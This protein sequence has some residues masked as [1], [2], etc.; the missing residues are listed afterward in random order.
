MAI[1][2]K[3]PRGGLVT[4]RLP[5]PTINSVGRNAANKRAPY[6]AE[7]LDNCF[8][9]LE[10]NIEKRPGFEV[11]PQYTIPDKT[12]W[13]FTDYS[14]R[15]DLYRLAGVGLPDE[16]PETIENK[17]FWY[18]WHNINEDNRYLVVIDFKARTNDRAL[19]YVFQIL[20]N[21]TWQDVTPCGQPGPASTVP[22]ETRAY[23]TFGSDASDLGTAKTAAESLQAVSVGTNIVIL[24]KNVYAGFTSDDDGFLFNLKGEKTT[25]EDIAGK[26]VTYYTASEVIKVINAGSDNRV[27]TADDIVLGYRPLSAVRNDIVKEIT[28]HTSNPLVV[29]VVL[30]DLAVSQGGAYVGY[31]LKLTDGPASGSNGTI[32]E[33]FGATKTARVSWSGAVPQVSGTI[34]AAPYQADAVDSEPIPAVYTSYSI[35]L[36]PNASD[37]GGT[38]VNKNFEVNTGPAT[39]E[40]RGKVTSYDAP[41]RTAKVIDWSGAAP[42]VGQSF[43]LEIS[44]PFLSMPAKYYNGVITSTPVPLNQKTLT[45]YTLLPLTYG[46]P[47][48]TT[49]AQSINASIATDPNNVKRVVFTSNDHLLIE[50]QHVFVDFVTGYTNATVNTASGNV[51]RLEFTSTNHGLK[52]DDKLYIDFVSGTSLADAIYTV[53][54]APTANTFTVL[55]NSN[56]TAITNG[57]AVIRKNSTDGSYTVETVPDKDTFTII[58]GTNTTAISSGSAVVKKAIADYYKD[59]KLQ[60]LYVTNPG[61]GRVIK[62]DPALN[63]AFVTN[64]LG[65]APLNGNTYNLAITD[66]TYEIGDKIYNGVD[67]VSITTPG[68]AGVTGDYENVQLEY[69]SG[70]VAT[71]YPKANITIANGEV[72]T[73]T[74]VSNYRGSGFNYTSNPT[75]MKVTTGNG[76]PATFRCTVASLFVQEEAKHIP[77]EDYSYFQKSLS[78]LGQKVNDASEIRLPPVIDDWYELNRNTKAPIDITASEMLKQ[79]Y[80][81]S[82]PYGKYT[83]EDGRFTNANLV[84][85]RGKVYFCSNP[86][87]SLTSG[88]YRVVSWAEN[89]GTQWVQVPT[90]TNTP[91]IQ[92]T[93]PIDTTNWVEIKP[94]GRPYLQKVRTPE[95]WSVIDPRRMPQKLSL[96]IS[97]GP[98]DWTIGP[99][100]WTPRQSGNN[101][102]NPGPSVFRTTN[103]AELKQTQIISIAV[104]KDRLWFAA[105]DVAFSSQ[106]G[107]YES[108]FIDDPSNIVAT[109]PIDI[110]ASSNAFAQITHMVPFEDYIFINTKANTQFQLT[111]GSRD[112]NDIV[113][114]PF[115]VML[116]PATYYSAASFVDPQTIGSQLYFFD[117]RKLYLFTGKTNLGMNSAVEVSAT[118]N[119]YLPE[120]YGFACVGHAQNSVFVTDSDNP[121]HIYIYTIRFSG[122][123]V[124]QNSF[125]RYVLDEESA[126]YS[127]QVY[128]K[129]LYAIIHKNDRVL[130]ERTL[131][132]DE[133]PIIPRMDHMFKVRISTLGEN[134]NTTY[135]P[136]LHETTYRL[137]TA[138]YSLNDTFRVVI[139]PP[140]IQNQE[141]ISG[142]AFPPLVSIEEDGA[143]MNVVVLGR[144]DTEGAYV[145]IG[146]PFRMEVELSPLFVRDENGNIVDGT[147]NLRTVVVRHFNTG[148]YDIVV[149]HRGRTPIVSSFTAI[150]PDFTIQEDALPLE[151]WAQNGEFVG[152][153]FGFSESTKIKLVSEYIT[154]V[155]IS[156]IEF[157]GKF[158]QKYSAI[159]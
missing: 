102:N 155:N 85:G 138:N 49:A 62:Y 111:A 10:R 81:P 144:F 124:I 114:T 123:R 36:G 31:S 148:N 108:F 131:L 128:D 141:D 137:P 40:T 29:D 25:E 21:G 64:W 139:A 120:N 54:T 116:S 12:D 53:D 41:T 107:D 19:F 101:D 149:S 140:A 69:H 27:F 143:Y 48:A 119:D 84:Q 18:Y 146:N 122:D 86:F 115:N 117:R 99:I 45:P 127:M 71:E 152:K 74:I 95:K 59:Y 20:P 73:C 37:V 39:F 93:K 76:I 113:L 15:V 60:T 72:T 61:S 80:D 16:V 125:Y 145:Y 79:L 121:N 157:K 30:G 67:T 65:D 136:G 63:T 130:I 5:V 51:K 34:S 14:T 8:V 68:S 88:Y 87:L 89:A 43:R 159:N 66:T 46:I 32:I 129:Y 38:Y 75:V 134:P 90:G 91:K 142:V 133:H 44:K 55:I 77:V 156:A 23:L 57:T 126:V 28:V 78:Y 158:K 103:R 17:D 4:T 58:L 132:K 35:Y 22:A 7:N 135:N 110:R 2:R 47:L 106:I 98:C 56:T 83:S 100:R 26:A 50:G 147:L 94:A 13:D 24:N 112:E 82:H 150:R 1:R 109:D 70:A 42:S 105:D 151:A 92:S 96:A 6:E 104:F 153:V 52:K 33:Y 118:A 97:A 154:P 11:V 9:S 3:G